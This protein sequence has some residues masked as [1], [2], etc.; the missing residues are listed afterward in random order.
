MLN[1][2]LHRVV[3]YL[4]AFHIFKYFV[5]NYDFAFKCCLV[6]NCLL[7]YLCLNNNIVSCFNY[8][9]HVVLSLIL[10]FLFT[11]FYSSCYFHI[12]IYFYRIF[13][14]RIFISMFLFIMSLCYLIVFLS[15][16]CLYRRV[17]FLLLLLLLLLLSLFLSMFCFSV[18]FQAQNGSP[19][20]RPSSGKPAARQ[21]TGPSLLA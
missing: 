17:L 3:S 4:I 11:V 14:H 12:F 2:V 16:C 10:R 9:C 21:A 6:L 19:G 15:L 13:Y 5:F 1:V 20:R 7:S 18:F 8:L